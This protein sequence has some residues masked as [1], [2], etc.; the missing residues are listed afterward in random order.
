MESYTFRIGK[1][2]P[3]SSV[4]PPPLYFLGLDLGQRADY[5]AISIIQEPVWV[6]PYLDTWVKGEPLPIAGCYVAPNKLMETLPAFYQRRAEQAKRNRDGRERERLRTGVRSVEQPSAPRE[7]PVLD[8]RYLHRWPLGTSYPAIVADVGQL[9]ARDPLRNMCRLAID[10]TGVGVAITDL[11]KQAKIAHTAISITGGNTVNATSGQSVSVPKR[12]L[13]MIVQSLLQ[14][15]RLRLAAR[16]PLLDTLKAELQSFEVKISAV[17]GHDT[18]EAWRSGDH[19]DIVLA[20]CLAVW[21]REWTN[22]RGSAFMFR[23][24]DRGGGNAPAYPLD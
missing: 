9:M 19:D 1:D 22:E 6:P 24:D 7:R 21:L 10:S 13:A 16:M 23:Y 3:A 2:Q 12:D 4:R 14:S 18:Y 20:T 17:S 5:S 15:D 11:F 8:L